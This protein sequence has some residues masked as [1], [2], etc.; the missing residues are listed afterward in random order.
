M[1]LPKKENITVT[2]KTDPIH[3]HYHPLVSVFMNARLTGAL[4]VMSEGRCGKM[5]DVG[6]GGGVFLPEL[7]TRCAELYGVDIHDRIEPV[8]EML[9]KEAVPATLS[10]GDVTKLPF[11]DEQ[12][13]RVICLS[14]LEFVSDL[15][16]A[17]SE[18]RRVLKR[19][20]EA[21]IGFPVENVVTDVAFLLIGINARRAHPVNQDDILSAARSHFTVEKLRTFPAGL[22]LKL[23]LFAHCRLRR[24]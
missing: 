10:F 19:G 2:G 18:L 6:Y 7:A 15:D 9:R 23:A 17:F 24:A 22:P 13:D 16:R 1:R 3:R 14:V 8:R 20:G 5:L 4:A 12:F 21:V 11:P